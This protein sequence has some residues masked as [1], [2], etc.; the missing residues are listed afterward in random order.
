VSLFNLKGATLA[1]LA[2]L[3]IPVIDKSDSTGERDN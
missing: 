1:R 3:I 2:F